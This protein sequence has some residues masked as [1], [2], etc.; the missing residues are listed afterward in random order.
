MQARF[1]TSEMSSS[2]GH[3]EFT[4]VGCHHFYCINLRT[5]FGTAL[6]F[7]HHVSDGKVFGRVLPLFVSRHFV[8]T[9]SAHIFGRHIL[10]T[11]HDDER[12]FKKRRSV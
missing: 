8:V 11:T 12:N 7:T 1:R 6:K 5:I 2:K 9:A 10:D 3:K 4:G